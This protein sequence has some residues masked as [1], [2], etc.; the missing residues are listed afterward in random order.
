MYTG[1]IKLYHVLFTIHDDGSLGHKVYRKPTHTDRYLHYNSFHHP[2]IKNSVCKTLINR[3][4]TICEVSTIDDE[5]EH[6]R[7]VLKMNGYPRHFIYN[8]M[9][10]PQSIQQKIEYQS[11]VCLPYIGPASQFTQNRKNF[12]E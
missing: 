9:K 1:H 10:T 6:L 8:A 4:K 12:E 7:N 2:S 3:A 11:S 5:L